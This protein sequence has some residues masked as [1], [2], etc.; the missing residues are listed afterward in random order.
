MRQHFSVLLSH[1]PLPTLIVNPANLEILTSN[2]HASATAGTPLSS[3]VGDECA[4]EI[5]LMQLTPG[6]TGT[7]RVRIRDDESHPDQR[8]QTAV[9]SCEYVD[10]EPVYVVVVRSSDGRAAR[11]EA[12]RVLVAQEL[13]F[14]ALADGVPVGIFLTN[15]DG[16]V[17]YV[18]DRWSAM[19]GESTNTAMLHGWIAGVHRDDRGRVQ[20]AWSRLQ[21]EHGTFDERF[22]YVRGDQTLW[23]SARAVPFYGEEGARAG[24]LGTFVDV[25]SLKEAEDKLIASEERYRSIFDNILDVYYETSLT[26]EILE[27]SPSIEGLGNFS[28]SELLGRSMLEFYT[29]QSARGKLIEALVQ[30]G[31]VHDYEV[32]LRD[33]K[34]EKVPCAISC[35]LERNE[36]GEPVKIIGSMRDIRQRKAIEEMLRVERY[37]LELIAE[38]ESLRTILENIVHTV[39]TQ[40]PGM[41]CSILTVD[42]DGKRLHTAAAPSLP[43]A[44]NQAVDGVEIGP[45]VGSCGRAAATKSCVVVEDIAAS[46]W[47]ADYKDLAMSHGLRACWSQPVV[48]AN[49][50]LLGTFAMYYSQPRKPSRHHLQLINAAARL[51]TVAIERAHAEEERH[52]L[53]AQMRQTQKLESLGVLAGGIAHDFNN[54]LTGIMGY[55]SLASHSLTGSELPAARHVGEIQKVAQRAADLTKQ[56]LAY[57]GKGRFLVMPVNLSKL[58]DELAHLLEIS[59]SKKARVHYDFHSSLPLVEVDSA[60][61]QQVVMN[62]ITNASEALGEQPGDIRISTGVIDA[63]QEY[64]RSPYIDA[65]LPEGRYVY[66]DVVDTG[67]GMN[68]E[69][70]SRIFDPFFTTKFTGRGLGMSAVLGI[71]RGHHGTIKVESA[72]G[73]GTTVRLLFPPAQIAE[74]ETVKRWSNRVVSREEHSDQ[75]TILIVDDEEMVRSIAALI[76]AESGYRVLTAADGAQALEVYAREGHAIDLVLLDLTMPIKDGVETLHELR[77]SGATVPVILSSGYTEQEVKDRI[78]GD[79]FEAFVQKPYT[80]ESMLGTIRDVLASA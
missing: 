27:V 36:N 2:V 41:L 57:S 59:I 62:L 68:E 39:E 24:F 55:A 17:M 15:A 5:R 34:G 19:T 30:Y 78:N 76:L 21:S 67:C 28:R 43:D 11:S 14:R 35:K 52:N 3:V 33:K 75:E 12:R 47:W 63:R 32:D 58:V 26:G 38:G 49:G 56:M 29:D 42:P 70:R 25:T 53:E 54:L 6:D 80:R 31:G 73:K 61:V 77:T 13:R 48:A 74:P 50:K 69:T 46:P 51:A 66:V 60:Q 71:M 79:R 65:E 9:V 22:R 37:T 44:Y 45:E 64:L 72:L 1:C 23:V 16:R 20:H 8:G 18:N 10:D 40:A 4:D 7:A